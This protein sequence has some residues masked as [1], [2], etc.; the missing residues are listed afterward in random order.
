MTPGLLV[1]FFRCICNE[2]YQVQRQPKVQFC[3]LILNFGVLPIGIII[4]KE[5]MIESTTDTLVE[6]FVVEVKY[7]IDSVPHAVILDSPNVDCINGYFCCRCQSKSIYYKLT[8][9][10]FLAL[11]KSSDSQIDKNLIIE[12]YAKT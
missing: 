7:N 4:E 5:V 6:W 2:C 11:N 3:S 9:E 8:A 10:V 1:S 12:L